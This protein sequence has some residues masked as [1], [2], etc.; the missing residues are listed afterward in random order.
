MFSV[1]KDAHEYAWA[2]LVCHMSALDTITVDT[3]FI[4]L[5]YCSEACCW[6][7]SLFALDRAYV[8]PDLFGLTDRSE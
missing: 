2:V 3:D 7:T 6:G 1:E 5:G 8:V 4:F